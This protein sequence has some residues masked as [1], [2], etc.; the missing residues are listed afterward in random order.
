MTFSNIYFEYHY[1]KKTQHIF[2]Y[3]MY[4]DWARHDTAEAGDGRDGGAD[5]PAVSRVGR[6]PRRGGEFAV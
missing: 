6:P 4:L 2:K 1:F 5:S 3:L